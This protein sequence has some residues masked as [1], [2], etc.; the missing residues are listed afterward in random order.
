MELVL[1]MYAER[2]TISTR[3][4]TI[5]LATAIFNILIPLPLLQTALGQDNTTTATTT[6]TTTPGGRLPS[7]GGE[8]SNILPENTTTS[9][10][11]NTTTATVVEEQP[12]Q[13][14]ELTET[15]VADLARQAAV[16]ILS[17][18][19]APAST[20]GWTINE[21]LMQEDIAT[22]A[23]EGF[24]TD[25]ND[26]TE[27]SSV[28][29]F[30]FI[31]DPSRYFME[32]NDVRRIDSSAVFGGSGF[33]VTPQGHIVTNAHVVAGADVSAERRE[34]ISSAMIDDAAFVLAQED[35]NQISQLTGLNIDIDILS[36]LELANVLS[37]LQLF[38][39]AR[40]EIDQ[41]GL[42]Q[43]IFVNGIAIPEPAD[44]ELP[45]LEAR[46]IGGAATGL[47]FP[48]RDVGIIKVDITGQAG[49]N[50]PTLPLGGSIATLKTLDDIIIVGFP[51]AI[52]DNPLFTEVT[53]PVAISAKVGGLYEI[54]GIITPEGTGW[55]AIQIGTSLS[56]GISGGPAL[57]RSGNVIG[58]ATFGISDPETGG[59]IPGIGFLVP[60]DIIREFLSTANIQPQE[61]R[62]TVLYR[63]ALVNFYGGNYEEARNILQELQGIS[64]NNQ[65]I[66]NYISRAT[67]IS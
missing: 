5:V 48:G 64:P 63:D 57:D 24:I 36:D 27:I 51:G 52:S 28:Q 40:I 7:R 65:D 53:N 67:T 6:I 32:T 26:P 31:E 3:I 60:T 43:R 56:G 49:Q 11:Q 29:S 44:P 13:Q 8:A 4:V 46:L 41:Q 55:T 18:Y 50:L 25:P 34:E 17:Y 2:R 15:L 59:T 38:Y 58:I 12:Q 10:V 47:P 22:L 62:F 39:A 16:E 30:L 66:S 61:S 45:G 37:A 1:L 23:Q 20:F 9:T 35:L 14:T 42:L 19:I 54:L 21:D 33:I